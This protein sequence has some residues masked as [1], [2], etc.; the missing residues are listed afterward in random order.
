MRSRYVLM[1]ITTLALPI[2]ASLYPLIFRDVNIFLRAEFW[3]GY[4]AYIG[5]VLLAGVALW[6]NEKAHQLNARMCSIE[7][8]K[9][10][11]YFDIT[12]KTFNN[13]SHFENHLSDLKR[14]F[15]TPMSNILLRPRNEIIRCI[16][17]NLFGEFPATGVKIDTKIRYIRKNH[18][19]EY[20]SLEQLLETISVILFTNHHTYLQYIP[21]KTDY[22]ETIAAV[23]IT[24]KT[25][26]NEDMKFVYHESYVD[27]KKY[28]EEMSTPV[29]VNYFIRRNGEET[30][31]FENTEHTKFP[32]LKGRQG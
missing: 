7:E 16:E 31:L 25:T 22:D 11:P 4:M 8:A 5:T 27:P 14:M 9:S 10:R 1:I 24:Y 21:P 3:Y 6:Q 32:L 30:L 15:L 23:T 18:Q 2:F 12:L 13:Y 29:N 28:R 26:R 20:P 17:L 19:P